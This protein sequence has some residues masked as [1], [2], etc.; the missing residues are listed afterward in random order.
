MTE[1]YTQ[2]VID[3]VRARVEPFGYATLIDE[4]LNNHEIEVKND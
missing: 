3:K 2:A 4:M 1:V